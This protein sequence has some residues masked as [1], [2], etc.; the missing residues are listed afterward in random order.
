MVTMSRSNRKICN[1]NQRVEILIKLTGYTRR[2]MELG[3]LGNV[4][5]E[6]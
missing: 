2:K 3:N 5:S 1:E 4:W 6:K